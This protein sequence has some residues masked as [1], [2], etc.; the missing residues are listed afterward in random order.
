[1]AAPR[2]RC[3]AQCAARGETAMT[4]NQIQDVIQSLMRTID[5]KTTVTVE[6]RADANTPGVTVQLRCA[7]RT[8]SLQLTEADLSAAQTDLMR[9]NRVRAALK[10][11]HDRMWDETR[12]IFSTKVEH[13]KLEGAGWFHPS[14]RGRGR[15]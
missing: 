4:M 12:Y 8:G 2:K 10:R 13:Q 3:E 5:K 7:N 9:R 6:P 1:M 11:A 15:R 14:Q